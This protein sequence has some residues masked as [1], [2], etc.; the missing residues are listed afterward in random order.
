MIPARM[1]QPTVCS[2]RA[3]LSKTSPS[4]WP[5]APPSYAPAPD[6][7]PRSMHWWLR[8][9]SPVGRC[10]PRTWTILRLSPCTPG[11]SSS[12]GCEP[13]PLAHA[14]RFRRSSVRRLR[15]E[16]GGHELSTSLLPGAPPLRGAGPAQPGMGGLRAINANPDTPH[17]PGLRPGVLPPQ[18]GKAGARQEVSNAPWCAPQH[19]LPTTPPPSATP[20]AHPPDHPTTVRCSP[21]AGELARRSRD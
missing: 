12:S 10:S 8:S 13:A 2:R 18:G 5:A 19:T 16:K 20:P 21:P 17:P 4:R 6:R 1:R 7:D 14:D 11:M 9:P 15:K 3:T